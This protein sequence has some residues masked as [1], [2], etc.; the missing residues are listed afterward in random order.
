MPKAKKKPP[1]PIRTWTLDGWTL[2]RPDGSATLTLIRPDGRRSE[3]GPVT[4]PDP[5]TDPAV[6][7]MVKMYSE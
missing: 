5:T 4:A 1:A 3:L 6:I 2:S 7:E